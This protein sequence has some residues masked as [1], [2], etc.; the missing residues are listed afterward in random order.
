MPPRRTA[1]MAA[2][3]ESSEAA[4]SR[5]GSETIGLTVGTPCKVGDGGV[6]RDGGI[7]TGTM[8]RRPTSEPAG[9]PVA[10]TCGPQAGRLTCSVMRHSRSAQPTGPVIDGVHGRL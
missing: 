9:A 3:T 2:S 1:S 8:G 7:R 4:H 5:A 10:A 6:R